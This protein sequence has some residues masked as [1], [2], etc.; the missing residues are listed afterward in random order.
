MSKITDALNKLRTKCTEEGTAPH[1]NS[2]DE[3]LDCIATHWNVSGGGESSVFNVV[4][5]ATSAQSSVLCHGDALIIDDD[6]GSGF[7]QL[8][9]QLRHDRLLFRQYFCVGHSVFS[10]P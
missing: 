3:I 6:T 8:V 4:L 7:L 1:G 5:T 2:I 10:P 9:G